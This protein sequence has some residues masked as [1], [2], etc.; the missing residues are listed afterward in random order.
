LYNSTGSNMVSTLADI[1]VDQASMV[2]PQTSTTVDTVLNLNASAAT[3]TFSISNPGATSEY[4]TALTIYDSLGNSHVITE[5]FTKTAAQTWQWNATIDGSDV[6]G[7]TAGTP[8]LFGSGLLS[9]DTSGAL[10][11]TQPVSLYTGSVTF[12]NGIAAS[13]INADFTGTTQYG[14]PSAIQSINQ[15]GY[16]A[17][18]ISG[19]TIN[20]DGTIFGY[21]TNGQVRNLA[22]LV[23]ANF[24]NLNGLVR[25]GEMLYKSSTESGDPLYNTPGVGGM[26]KISAGCLE[27]SNVDLAAEF[28]KMIIT[29]RAYQANSKVISTTDDMLAQ[30]LNVK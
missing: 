6:Q 26:G 9:F 4:S 2:Q 25:D 7:G 29:Q 22:Q 16:A 11:T 21:Y 28:I 10:T 19:I 24:P 17:G 18:M 14:S 5:Y 3:N 1:Q 13:A 8:V 23:L 15:D 30:L 12:R 20:T 27:E